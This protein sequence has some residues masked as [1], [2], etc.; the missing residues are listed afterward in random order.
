MHYQYV[1]S[2]VVGLYLIKAETLKQIEFTN[3]EGMDS[4]LQNNDHKCSYREPY[5]RKQIRHHTF[6]LILD[7]NF[8][9][10][11]CASLK[12]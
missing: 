1:L 11:F 4:I 5:T 10:K 2:C 3:I 12:F 6:K 9:G 8:L 7:H